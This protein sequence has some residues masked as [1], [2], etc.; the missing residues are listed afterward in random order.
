MVKFK[1]KIHFKGLQA[2]QV[3]IKRPALRDD[4]LLSAKEFLYNRAKK[5][6]ALSSVELYVSSL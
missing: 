1:S 6:K 3:V 2:R 5:S 4:E